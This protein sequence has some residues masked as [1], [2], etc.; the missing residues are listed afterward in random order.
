MESAE[1]GGRMSSPHVDEE[2]R[3]KATVYKGKKEK[4]GGSEAGK[5]KRYGK[6]LFWYLEPPYTKT[7]YFGLG[8]D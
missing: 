4:K 8:S 5:R 6:T 1:K 3:G 7:Q 2:K